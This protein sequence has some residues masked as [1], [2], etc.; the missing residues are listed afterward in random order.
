MQFDKTKVCTNRFNFTTSSCKL[1]WV[2]VNYYI[3][4]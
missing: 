1:S 4:I 3:A 2:V